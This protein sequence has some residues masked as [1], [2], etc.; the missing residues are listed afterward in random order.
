M[1]IKLASCAVL[2]VASESGRSCGDCAEI[3][4]SELRQCSIEAII[5]AISRR[6]DEL[7]AWEFAG[8]TVRDWIVCALAG[9]LIGGSARDWAAGTSAG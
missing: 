4:L 3:A 6:D 9:G 2:S 8:D 5:L 7:S 1:T